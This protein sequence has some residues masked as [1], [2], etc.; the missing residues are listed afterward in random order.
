MKTP[1]SLNLLKTLR[2]RKFLALAGSIAAVLGTG[3]AKA[4]TYYWDTN[5]TTAGSGAATGTWGTSLFWSTV[6][7]GTAAT[8]NTT[9]TNVD[10]VF[11]SAGT[12]GTTGIVTINGARVARS[13][14]FDDPVNLTLSGGTS[15]TIGGTGGTPGIFVASTATTAANTIS[16]PIILAS[17]SSIQTAGTGILSITGGITGAFALTLQNNGATANGV[18]ISTA[19]LNN[20]GT[21]TNSGT[22]AGGTLIS[23]VIGT[24]VTGINQ[25]SA[26]STLTLSGANTYTGKTTVSAGTLSF[27]TIGN[28]G[29]VSSAL[30]A[31][32]TVANGTI[33]LAGTLLYTG[34]VTSSDRVI[35]ATG[36]MSVTNNGTGALTLTGGVTGAGSQIVFRGSGN[37]TVSGLISANNAG[38]TLNHTDGG[39]LTLTNNSNSFTGNILLAQGTL[40]ASSIANSGVVSAI[41]AGSTITM[42]QNNTSPN[43]TFQFAGP[44]GGSSDRTFSLTRGSGATA[45]TWTLENTVASQS[46]NLS[47][48]L[49]LSNPA[50]GT[51]TMALALTGA[52]DGTISGVISQ[53]GATGAGLD[54]T[55]TGTGT[56]TLS[57]ANTYTGVTTISGGTLRLANTGAL[58]NTSGITMNT[59]S[60]SLVFGTDAAFTTLPTLTGSSGAF[61]YTL[62]SDRT[63]SGA[64]LTHAL[65][66]ATFGNATWAF[67]SGSNVASGTAGLSFTGINMSGGSAGTVTLSPTTS[68]ISLATVTASASAK[69]LAL[70]GTGTGSITGAITAGTGVA[71]T[72]ANASTWTI[73]GTG[74]TYAGGMTLSG[75]T[76]NINSTTA[77][78]ATAGAFTISGASTIDNT[79]AG[80]IT[81]ANNNPVALNSNFT[82]G[83]TQSL[84]LGTGAV[85]MNASR[86]IAANGTGTLTL[87][88]TVALVANTLTKTGTGGL[89]LGGIVSG[90][91]AAG[92]TAMTISNGVLTASGANT[93]TG[94]IAVTG[95]GVFAMPG[96]TYTT[97]APYG[98]SGTANVYKQILL[99]NGGT[100]RLTSGTFND[101]AT[102]TNQAGGIIFNIGS[103]GGIL[104]VASNANLTIDDGSGTGTGGGASQIQGAG[105]LTKTGL[106][107]LSLGTGTSN[108]AAFTGAI[109]VSAGT[110]TTGAVSTTPF[111]TTTTGTT[112][113]SGAALSLGTVVMTAAEPLTLFGTGLASAP[114]GALTASGTSTWVG[115]ITIG[116]GGATIG[117]GAGALTVNGTINIGSSPNVLTINHGAGRIAVAGVISGSGS[118]N[119]TGSSTGDYVPSAANTYT[120]GTTLNA[121]STT[122]ISI[123]STGTA[124]SPANGPFGAGATP[125]VLN[126]GQLRNGT[127]AP[128]TIG[129]TVT[130]AADTTFFTVAS[131]KT[132]TFSGPVTITGA[133]RTLTST[134]GANVAGTNVVFLG[135]IGDGGNALGIT[136]AG[137]GNLTLTGANTYTG[138]TTVNAGFLNVTNTSATG[139]LTVA[140]TVAGGAI[141]SLASNSANPLGSLTTLSLGS[142][143]GP[144][145]IALDLG[146]SSDSISTANAATATNTIN[147]ALMGI[148]GF[149][150]GNYNLINALSGLTSSAPTY[151]LTS[152]PG[153]FTYGFTNTDSQ[154]QLNVTAS[155]APDVFWRGGLN[156]SWTTFSAGDT[157]WFTDASGTTN[158]QMNPGAGQFV[159]FSN[160]NVPGTAITTTLDNNFS[161]Q[162][163]KF[164]ANPT[165]VSTVTIAGGLTPALQTGVLT[166]APSAS[167]DGIALPQGSG[168]VSISAPIA[169]GASQTWS[170][171]SSTP[172][173]GTASSLTVSGPI[174]GGSGNSVT[175]TTT[176]GTT[177]IIL[178][179]AS[180]T[181]TYS[182]GSTVNAS[183]IVQGGATNAFS[184]NTAWTVDG[185]LN[186][187]AFSQNT[188][189]LVGGSGFVQNASATAATLTIGNDNLGTSGSPVT[190][191]GTIQNGSTAALG[192]TKV[193]AG[194]QL[195]SGPNTYTGTTT[196]NAGT[197]RNGSA[198][199]FGSAGIGSGALALA[200]TGVFELNGF[201]AAVT[202]VSGSVAGSTIANNGAS[203]ATLA[204]S[205]QA[206]TISSL[207]TDGGANKLAVTLRNANVGA[208]PFLLTS[209]NTFSGG[210]TLIDGTA[211]G[212]GTRLVINSAITTVGSPGAITSS[213]FG[214]GTITIGQTAT[215]K[216]GIY[217]STTGNITLANAIVFNTALGTDRVGIRTDVAGIT[218]SGVITANLA[219][220][221]FTSNTTTGTSFALTNQVTG[222]SGLVLDIVSLGSATTSFNVTL[223]NQTVNANDYA[224]DTVVNFGALTGKSATLNLAAANQLPNG[225]GKG[226]VVLN[227]T[228]T[229]VGLLNLAGFSD[230]I[231]GLNGNGTVDGTTGTPT[232]TIGDGNA[233]GNFS[234]IIQNTAGTLAITKIGTGTQTFTGVNT[235]TGALSV[236]GGLVAFASSP[237]STGPLGNSTVVN[238]GGGGLSYTAAGANSLNRPVVIGS[239]DGT[240]NVSS[241]TGT[242]NVTSV[243]SSGGSLIKTGS[244]AVVING[245]SG[246]TSLNGGASSVFVNDGTLQA[247]FGSNGVGAI[248]IGAT[249][250]LDMRNSSIDALTLAN[251]PAALTLTGGA[252][253]GFEFNGATNDSIDLNLTGT[254]STAGTVTLNF[255]NFAA[256]VA[257]GTYNLLT[258]ASGGLAGATYALGVAPNGFNYTINSS[259]NLVSV[260]ATA[261]T[262]IYWRGGQDLS[263][264]TLGAG[265]ANWTTDAAGTFDAASTPVSTDT[266]IFSATGAPVVGNTITTTLDGAF[267]VDSVQFANVPAGITAVTVN[268]GTGGTLTLTPVSTSGGIRV[269]AG[270]GNA[271]IAT[272]LT[273]AAAQT[274]DVDPSGSLTVNG[275]TVFNAPVSKTNSGALTLAGANSG[276]GTITLTGGTL[277]INSSTAIGTG[278]F[279]I[280]AGTTINS[281]AGAVALTTAN[282]QNW[283]GDFT[284]TGTNNLNLGSGAVSFNNS[285]TITANGSVL[286]VGGAIGDGGN[287]RSLTKTGPGT[288]TLTGANTYTGGTTVSNGTLNLTGNNTLGTGG[289]TVN[290]ATAN[291][292]GDN[293]YSGGTVLNGGSLTLSGNNTLGTGGITVTS[294]TATVSG[295]NTYSGGTVVTGGTVTLSGNNTFGAGVVTLSGGTTTI[296]G[297][298]SYTGTTTLNGGTLNLGN[299]A[300]IGSGSLILAGGTVD[301]SSGGALALSSNNAQF[302]NG[303]LTFTGTNSLDLGTGAVAMSAPRAVTVSANS[304]TV[305]GVI[306]GAGF[307]LTKSGP[308]TLIL[309]GNNVYTGGTIIGSGSATAGGGG[310][311]ILSGNNTAATGNVLVGN[312][313]TLQLQSANALGTTGVTGAQLQLFGGSML[314]L[315]ADSATTFNGTSNLGGLNTSIIGIDVDRLTGAGSNNIL[316]LSPGVSPIGNAVTLNIT[317][318]NGYSLALD[319]FRNVTG[320]ATNLTLNPTTA[321]VSLVGYNAFNNGVNSSTLTLG[322]TAT[323]NTVTGVIANQATGSTGTGTTALTKTGSSTWTLGGANTY[324][325]ATIVSAGTLTLSGNRTA[326]AGAITVGNLASNTATLNVS[327][328]TFTTGTF[329]VA[330]GDNTVAGIVNQTGGTLTMGG[331]QLL[332]GNGG[333]GTAAGSNSTGTYNLSGGTLNTVAGA[334][335]V[336]VGT[337]TGGTGIF[338]LSGTG[339]L[340]MPATSTLQIGRSDASAGSN[341]TGTFTQTGGTATVGILQIGGQGTNQA[342]T[343]ATLN[344]SSGNFSA[345][346]FNFLSAA[347]SSASVINIG[348]TADVTL[349]AFPTTRGAGST[350]TLNFDGGTLRPAA[351]SATYISGLTNAFI[352][353]GGARVDVASG[354]NITIPQ[355]LLTDLVSTGGGLT[356]DGAGTLAITGANTYTGFTTVNAGILAA[357]KVLALP[358]QATAHQI[359]V[360]PLATLAA[361]VG[362]TGEFAAADIDN[363]LANVDFNT[364]SFLGFDTTTAAGASF[365]YASNI[366]NGIV[367]SSLGVNKIGTNTLVLTGSNTYTGPTVIAGGTLSVATLADIGN[368]S[369]IGAGDNTSAATNTAS[370]VF[371]AAT[372]SYTGADATSDRGFTLGGNGTIL[373]PIAGTDLALGGKV[374][375]GGTLIFGTGGTTVGSTS[376][377]TLGGNN[378]FTGNVTVNNGNLILTNSNSLGAGTKTIT[379]QVN[380]T[381][382]ANLSLD[383]TGGDI[384][385]PATM[386]FITS[387]GG[388]GSGISNVAGNNTING[389]FTLTSGNGAT[390]FFSN[391]GSLTLNGS[392]SANTG[393][394]AVIFQ[395]LGNGT[396]NGTISNGTYASPTPLTVNKNGSGIWTL[397]GDNTFSGATAIGEGG[398]SVSSINSVTGGSVS[399][400]LGRPTTVATGTI[401]LGGGAVGF[402]AA[403][404]TG[405]LIYTGSGETT[406]RVL[407]L[408]GTTGGG[409][410]DQS[411]TGLLKFTSAMTATGVGSKTLTLGGSTAGTGEIAGAIV[412]NAAGTN[413]TSLAKTGT[414]MWTLSGANTFTGTTTVSNGTLVLNSATANSAIP[415]DNNT[416]TTADIVINGGSLAIAASEQIGNTGSINMTSGSLG[417]SGSNLTETI[418]KLTNSG[419][420]FTTGANLLD[421]LGATTTWAGG[422]N[423]ISAG[424]TVKDKH[425]V[426]TGGTNTVQQN[427]TL[428][429]KSGTGTVGLFMGGTSSPTI[430][431]DSDASIPGEIFLQQDVTVDSSL[432]SGT[433]QIRSGGSAAHAGSIDL[434]GGVRTFTVNNGSAAT[435]LLISAAITNG[436]ITKAD[437]GTM[438]LS[439]V[440]SYTGVTT[441]TGGTLS[442]ATIGNGGSAGNL[443]QASTTASNLV[444]DGG[445]LQYTGATASTNRDF[446]INSG[447]T[448]TFDVTTNTLTVSGAATSTTG[449]LTKSGAGTLALSGT[450]TFTGA[451]T[452]TDGTL[453]AAGA[454]TLGT[455]SSVA[456][457]SGGT[458][459]LSG[460]GNQVADT[461]AVELNLGTIRSTIDGLDET[462]GTLTLS[463]NSTIDFG[464][465]A[466]GNTFRFSDSS[467]LT[468]GSATLSIWNWTPGV[469]HLYVGV[470]NSGLNPGQ[471]GKISFYSDSG[472]N[473]SNTFAGS[474]FN[475]TPFDGLNGEVSPVP[476]PSSIATLMGILGLI[477]IRERRKQ[478][479]SRKAGRI[480]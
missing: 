67:T 134:V 222:P 336:I 278:T 331:S 309:T 344:L 111:G 38:G 317:G 453:E 473:L 233:A 466:S 28:V 208:T 197:L 68:T 166:I 437:G 108:F 308:G 82:Y 230:T 74:N 13:I 57:G 382:T 375:G 243:T 252:T 257:G 206:S 53:N 401:A 383:G 249:G 400:N 70:D 410:I 193:G 118:V 261:F 289:L 315:R 264:N 342:G 285:L 339:I 9:I 462:M 286:T 156:N 144:T 355:A 328:G 263:W 253:L 356:K 114:A 428:W 179:A 20:T 83:G 381:G 205:A 413:I 90:S 345:V 294:G 318:S 62:V 267:A 341:T 178:S 272:P 436:G 64:G 255:F 292:S 247:G 69:T 398:V 229:G 155:A 77:L 456:V 350:A 202:N 320:T 45:S 478:R 419:G 201:N 204:I 138:P 146:S 162:G 310:T 406:D 282:V 132:L 49:T 438:L 50:G 2:P 362:G 396:V 277:N 411:G 467:S 301:N 212:A 477:G 464:T 414:G 63:T 446:T 143:T 101:N 403:T 392:I 431:L 260:T 58:A 451:T 418:D 238:L 37:I 54:V 391:A 18:T 402:G 287:G 450:N 445:T 248:T 116:A 216:A 463:G 305:G 128:F 218:L 181:S 221:T 226:N 173:L 98:A 429:V 102:T 25:N 185:T 43:A 337:N 327:A 265:S 386:S 449:G 55:K 232:L 149:G 293:T 300:A 430:T 421:V 121:G 196:V 346:T 352:K 65:G 316:S 480:A 73:S 361:N 47:G 313:G 372:L 364:G 442:V 474:A 22:G 60:N 324:T 390:Q 81:N 458:L 246:I 1:T 335:G 170:V 270:G 454:A 269:L 376:S 130:L 66:S 152:A 85:T 16:T 135:A 417:F 333:A 211:I 46:L 369:S 262:P 459:L 194:V 325:G 11:F 360:A 237:T 124:G 163:L 393:G 78:G 217:F 363:L 48:N 153:G 154:V 471:L 242:L 220:A 44:S 288:V 420:T 15:L 207:V 312:G 448:A 332:L 256:G 30:G 119:V 35:N 183:T 87:G 5:S 353:A 412:D 210:V 76:L 405:T 279:N 34:A 266:V 110:L 475:G 387:L 56:W 432:T 176:A 107:T 280:G 276:S 239:S 125:L 137:G 314:Q 427:G 26:T 424:G 105:T 241:S 91:T 21:V 290:G 347:P 3:A 42:G 10:D 93:F 175:F 351:A 306:S 168:A 245:I 79:T 40:N 250:N 443:G 307:S 192:I 470:N 275:G 97:A 198:T 297:A 295:N 147:F 225:A 126:G 433:A 39:T 96:A 133:T 17:A 120:G 455:T 258:S 395:G 373:L 6:A 145:T 129:N 180:G 160:A 195:L 444:F 422:T 190:F 330:T 271:T 379:V 409:A 479:E 254:A 36:V 169:L 476:E 8:A 164:N 343:N 150:A 29:A 86:S 380:T 157:N 200:G 394:R 177:P 33:D 174:T 184:T 115:P 302:W 12:N 136:K 215:D 41:G 281:T 368:T 374:T 24:S 365:T 122:A 191:G 203:D 329:A 439:G 231:N 7:A 457:T 100:F 51:G 117:G 71:I 408:A 384:T 319:T 357:G 158:A 371:N 244:G 296:S 72:K 151:A 32:A 338:N 172:G 159:N 358:G 167:T 303:N 236:N 99:T 240:L 461:A 416:A 348:G 366:T 171:D 291:L 440:N 123:T 434:N 23:S 311:L 27:N 326:T 340:N 223:N 142:A 447:K 251:L 52:G 219:P 425:W 148:A 88:G 397:A 113:Q 95:S 268:P 234:G 259:A 189:S 19:S 389:N 106:G 127:G 112:I 407:N 139:A 370:L 141:F 187:G 199:S 469:D 209:A 452:I 103:G 274:W 59:A 465:F 378:D 299:S 235:F 426:I 399:S 161:V 75:G 304:L 322:G 61:T 349:P 354:K 80:S 404:S 367:G 423:T 214:T 104:D 4:A 472:V 321:N 435:D 359:S 377:L 131:E 441:L 227:T 228:G 182:G 468:W 385:L 94:N 415:T 165:G 109:V 224:G 89:T 334:L 92:T 283:N 298:N 388:V 273:V 14:T 188:G 186:T 460:S 213:P 323:G 140:P 284:F 84:N 31:P